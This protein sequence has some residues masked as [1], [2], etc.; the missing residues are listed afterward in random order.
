MVG[1][2]VLKQGFGDDMGGGGDMG[3]VTVTAAVAVVLSLSAA[4]WAAAC[5]GGGMGGMGGGMGGGMMGGGGGGNF[6]SIPAEKIVRVP[7][8]S[9]CLAHGLPEPS[10]KKTYRVVRTESFTQDFALQE[11]LKLVATGRIHGQVAQAA[12]WNLTDKMSWRELAAKSVKHVGGRRPTRY[13]SRGQL[14]AAQQLV[15]TA[16]ARAK[17]RIDKGEKPKQLPSRVRNAQASR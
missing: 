8:R 15:A 2:H 3:S 4:A 9:V 12:A 16:Q 5:M 14:I 17:E 10:A 13:F 7:F 6:F 1:V 11:L